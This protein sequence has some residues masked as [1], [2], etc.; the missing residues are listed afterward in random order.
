MKSILNKFSKRAVSVFLSFMIVISAV[1]GSITSF[2]VKATGSS[3]T[4]VVNSDTLTS[5]PVTDANSVVNSVQ[6]QYKENASK[7]V[8]PQ[9]QIPA[10]S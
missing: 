6:Y 4:R 7:E 2:I 8:G 9:K 10:K 5:S 1:G 3:I